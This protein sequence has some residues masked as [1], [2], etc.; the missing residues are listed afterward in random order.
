MQVEIGP[1]GIYF[2][3]K[4]VFRFCLRSECR[5]SRVAIGRIRVQHG[6]DREFVILEAR[7]VQDEAA[8]PREICRAVACPVP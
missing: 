4:S 5:R 7:D 6:L 8:D 2:W 3:V 1:C